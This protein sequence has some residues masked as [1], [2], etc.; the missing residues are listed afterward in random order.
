MMMIKKVT[1]ID[2][3]KDKKISDLKPQFLATLVI[4]MDVPYTS[5]AP[6]STRSGMAPPPATSSSSFDGILRALK[7]MFAWCRDTRQC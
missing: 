4:T 5:A 1:S 3:M 2:F 7:N 6:R